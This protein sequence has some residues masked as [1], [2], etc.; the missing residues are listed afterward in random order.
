MEKSNVF[1]RTGNRHPVALLGA[2]VI[3]SSFVLMLASPALAA[4]TATIRGI[5]TDGTTSKPV[6]NQ[7]LKLQIFRSGS[8][9]STKPGSTNAAGEFSFSGL[10]GGSVWSYVVGATYSDVDYISDV[11]KPKAGET[12]TVELLVYDPTDSAVGLE[13]D[14]WVVWI[15]RESGVAIQQDVQLTNTGKATYVG[16]VQLVEGRKGV[17]QLPLLEGAKNLQ[18]LGRFMQ[19]CTLVRGS[20][21]YHTLPM[22]PGKS[23]G[24]VRYNVPS[25]GDLSFPVLFKTKS[26]S[27][28]VPTDVKVTSEHV[29]SGGQIQDRGITYN[30]FVAKDLA[31]GTVVKVAT[32]GLRPKSVPLVAVVGL[33]VL[34]LAGGAVVYLKFGRRRSKGS[35]GAKKRQ[36]KSPP[37][38]ASSPQVGR[39]GAGVVTPTRPSAPVVQPA[40]PTTEAAG[41]AS[42]GQAELL[43]EE[44]AVLDLAFERGLISEAVYRRLRSMRK[45]ELVELRSVRVAVR[46]EE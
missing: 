34:V 23:T 35:Q 37:K 2:A 8:V 1:R 42:L 28:I 33:V 30:V 25:V 41:E 29:K 9:V 26:F 39:T 15:D 43:L 22:T 38:K 40:A 6:P 4:D 3:A 31:V 11:V 12:K 24:T 19:C 5:V 14:E 46:N 16:K 13:I 44:L 20:S 27:I 36:S 17:V 21:F 10:D 18:Y 7:R 32:E 45:A